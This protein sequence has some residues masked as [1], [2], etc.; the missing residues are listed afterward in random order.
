IW[1]DL[2][3]S[4][5]IGIQG[6]GRDLPKD[7]KEEK[8]IRFAGIVTQFFASMIVVDDEQEN[9][10]FI[11]WARPTLE[12]AWP[13]PK[14]PFLDDVTMRVNAETKLEPGKPVVHKY[15]LYNGPVKVRLLGQLEGDK[16]VRR[17]LVDRYE[18]TLH[19]NQLTDFGKFGFWTELIITC[20]N[21]M[22]WLLWF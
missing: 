9:K 19:L 18:N 2:Q 15:L 7:S 5:S 10:T 1:R 8:F 16:E 6:G 13:N 21:L 3:D 22:H 12:T 20:T 14:Q 11:A 4:K 17:E